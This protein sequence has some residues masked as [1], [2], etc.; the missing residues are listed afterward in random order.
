MHLKDLSKKNISRNSIMNINFGYSDFEKFLSLRIIK[1]MPMEFIEYF[2]SI[3]NYVSSLYN[4]KIIVSDGQ[5]WSNSYAKFWMAH[6]QENGTKLLY[7]QHG[8]SITQGTLYS[9]EFEER[10]SDNMI[11]WTKPIDKKHIQLPPVVYFNEKK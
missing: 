8:G 7:A 6:A 4:P 11:T 1:D 2:E 10:V 3:N 9:M 5:Y